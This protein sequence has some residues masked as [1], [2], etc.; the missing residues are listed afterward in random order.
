MWPFRTMAQLRRFWSAHVDALERHL[1]RV[2]HM[3]HKGHMD[4][5]TPN[6]QTATKS[7]TTEKGTRRER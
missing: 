7:Q 5:P 4:E 1:D 3:D 6:Q 2:G